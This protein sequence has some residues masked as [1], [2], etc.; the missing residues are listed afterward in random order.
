VSRTRSISRRGGVAGRRVGSGRCCAGSSLT[1]LGVE[2]GF[3]LF[4]RGDHSGEVGF[5]LPIHLDQPG[6][7]AALTSGDQG[8]GAGELVAVLAEELA[9]RQEV[10]A[11]EAGFSELNDQV[12]RCV[13][14]M[15]AAGSE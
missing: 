3:E 1:P 7:S 4:D 13:A 11:G 5:D 15:C 10:R 8:A 12:G 2:A 9:V 6:A 14:P